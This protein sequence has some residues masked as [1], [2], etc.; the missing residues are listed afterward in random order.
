MLNRIINRINNLARI[1]A[2]NKNGMCAVSLRAN[3]DKDSVFEGRNEIFANTSIEKTSVGFASYIAPNC[4]LIRTQVGKYCSIA[5]NVHIIVGN[6]P[7]KD[8]VSTH[9][10]F[11]S[12]RKFSSFSYGSA[13]LFVEFSYVDNNKELFCLIG[14]DVWLGSDVRII[15]GVTI[16]DGA[17]VAAG[18]VVTKDVEPYA[19][20]G[21]V[22]AKL[23]RYRFNNEEISYLLKLKWWDLDESILQKHVQDFMDINTLRKNFRNNKEP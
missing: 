10:L 4:S 2:I 14:N 9:P 23:I 11:F 5:S 21:G 6:H 15:N 8:F 20:V 12:N 1:I 7:T 18:A 13:N 22:P 3:I 17:I 19:I 16:G